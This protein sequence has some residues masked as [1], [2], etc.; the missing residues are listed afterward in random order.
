MRRSAAI[1]SVPTGRIGQAVP[2]D[3]HDHIVEGSLAVTSMTTPSAR[4]VDHPGRMTLGSAGASRRTAV[5]TSAKNGHPCGHNCCRTPPLM[6][7]G[8]ARAF[9][10]LRS[11]DRDS[12][13]RPPTV[14]DALFGCVRAARVRVEAAYRRL[15]TRERMA[16]LCRGSN[17]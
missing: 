2:S 16:V 11:E 17:D 1:G 13:C 12:T 8:R 4:Q 3:R 7:H 10:T 15:V 6:C 9:V 14:W 5:A